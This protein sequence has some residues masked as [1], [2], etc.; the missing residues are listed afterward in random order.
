LDIFTVLR[1]LAANPSVVKVAHYLA[2][3][4]TFLYYLGIVL[5]P[6]VY[7]TIDAAQLTLKGQYRFRSLS[8]SGLKTLV[9]EQFDV[10]LSTLDEVTTGQRFDKLDPDDS[11]TV[12]YACADTDYAF[13]L[14]ELFNS[15][16]ARF[17]LKHQYIVKQ[18]ESPTAV[19]CGIMRYNG[20]LVDIARMATCREQCKRERERLRNESAFSIG[21]VDIGANTSSKAFKSYLYDSLKLPVLKVTV[22][23]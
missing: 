1:E 22:K 6:P 16:F 3:E 10:E 4:A 21:D 9:S 12:A 17:M 13:R 18:I 11:D 23:N 5:R 2:C 20:L 15:W 7:D 19:F 8:D 14:R